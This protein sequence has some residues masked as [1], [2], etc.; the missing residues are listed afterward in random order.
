MEDVW[1]KKLE[2]AHADGQKAKEATEKKVGT[3]IERLHQL[4]EREAKREAQRGANVLHPT[5]LRSL[6]QAC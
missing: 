2:A 4:T 6:F 3:V 5:P 1:S